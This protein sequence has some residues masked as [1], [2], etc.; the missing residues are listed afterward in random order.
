[1]RRHTFGAVSAELSHRCPAIIALTRPAQTDLA[2]LVTGYHTGR[3]TAN[4]APGRHSAVLGDS[5]AVPPG[6]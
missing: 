2:G 5:L 1:M 4:G 6:R 3:L